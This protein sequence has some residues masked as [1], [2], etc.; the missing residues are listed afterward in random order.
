MYVYRTVTAATTKEAFNKMLQE[1][2]MWSEYTNQPSWFL[3]LKRYQVLDTKKYQDLVSN[4]N[5]IRKKL[6]QYNFN[7]KSCGC[8]LLEGDRYQF[9]LPYEVKL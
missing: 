8:F 9:I 4:K 7:N 6:L 2:E 5:V 1:E 3:S